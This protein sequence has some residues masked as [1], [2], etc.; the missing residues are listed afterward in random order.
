MC[1]GSRIGVTGLGSWLRSLVFSY[2]TG[3]MCFGRSR[4]PTATSN[5]IE[6]WDGHNAPVKTSG[7]GGSIS[8]VLSVLGGGGASTTPLGFTL[9]LE[10]RSHQDTRRSRDFGSAV[11]TGPAKEAPQGRLRLG[12]LE[13]RLGSWNKRGQGECLLS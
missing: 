6:H 4:R 3:K 10:G 13:T 1:S 11:G 7:A 8:V 12:T 9:D 2:S 5:I